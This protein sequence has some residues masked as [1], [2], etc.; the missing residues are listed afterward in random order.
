MAEWRAHFSRFSV[1]SAAAVALPSPVAASSTPVTAASSGE[2]FLTAGGPDVKLWTL[3]GH[4][5]ALFGQLA[6]WPTHLA[7]TGAAGCHGECG[8]THSGH[9]KESAAGHRTDETFCH[10]GRKLAGVWAV[11]S[12]VRLQ[13]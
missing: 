2:C 11:V 4:F 3:D 7:A 8:S 13:V 9:L 5:V 12:H 6:P 10:V 1:A